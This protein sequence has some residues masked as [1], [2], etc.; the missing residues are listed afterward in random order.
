MERRV[1]I[2]WIDGCVWNVMDVTW[3]KL[4]THVRL[5]WKLHQLVNSQLTEIRCERK[6]FTSNLT[7]WWMKPVRDYADNSIKADLIQKYSWHKAFSCSKTLRALWRPIL[8][9][10]SWM[11]DSVLRKSECVLL[12]CNRRDF[13]PKR[14]SHA[15]LLFEMIYTTV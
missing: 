10:H 1:Q 5:R 7:M 6:R 14:K 11:S 4:I 8:A 3:A 2:G 15:C 12:N 9:A 13:V